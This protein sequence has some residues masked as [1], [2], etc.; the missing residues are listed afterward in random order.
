MKS[1]GQNCQSPEMVAK[2]PAKKATKKAPSRRA[3]AEVVESLEQRTERK[4][5]EARRRKEEEKAW[6]ERNIA[7][8]GRLDRRP[9][10]FIRPFMEVGVHEIERFDLIHGITSMVDQIRPKIHSADQDLVFNALG[11]TVASYNLSR[12][13]DSLQS[14]ESMDDVRYELEK[15]RV[16]FELALRALDRSL[17]D[18]GIALEARS[19][20]GKRKSVPDWHGPC[21]ELAKSLLA[22]GTERRELVGKLAQRID[23]D[24][25]SIARVLKKA[26]IK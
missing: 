20:G 21:I 12:L 11:A 24:R 26:G 7:G 22:H 9:S 25:T 23:R 17:G 15:I 5:I 8:S 6:L 1:C 3:G 16:G 2:K 13:I 4:R 14:D 10:L 19:K 18:R